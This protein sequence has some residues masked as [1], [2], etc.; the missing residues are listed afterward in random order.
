MIVLLL[1]I[2]WISILFS[3]I[4]L[5]IVSREGNPQA[6]TNEQKHDCYVQSLEDPLLHRE[7]G[8]N[9]TPDTQERII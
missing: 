6:N 2:L 1:R 4:A 3:L 9:R 5:L 7:C 8:T